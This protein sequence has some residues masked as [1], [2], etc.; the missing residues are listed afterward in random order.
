MIIILIWHRIYTTEYQIERETDGI[1]RKWEV[2]EQLQKRGMQKK[3]TNKKK[4]QQHR[5]ATM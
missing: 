2:T 5:N 4:K 3:R 1:K